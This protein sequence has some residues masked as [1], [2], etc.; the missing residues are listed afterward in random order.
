VHFIHT[1]KENHQHVTAFHALKAG[2]LL[3]LMLISCCHPAGRARN[4]RRKARRRRNPTE[5]V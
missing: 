4:T 5:K 1:I 2:V 3:A